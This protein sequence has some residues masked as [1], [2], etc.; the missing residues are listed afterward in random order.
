MDHHVDDDQLAEAVKFNFKFWW[1]KLVSLEEKSYK[2]RSAAFLR[3]LKHLPG[4]YKL[5]FHFLTE[6]V[7]HCNGKCIISGSYQVVNDLFEKC[8]VFM[9]KM[10]RIW[11]LYIEFLYKQKLFNRF[12]ATLDR[13]E[14]I[15]LVPHF[16]TS[17]TTLQDMGSSDRQG[18]GFE[19]GNC[20]KAHSAKV[21]KAQS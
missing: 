17:D 2:E 6:S 16:S 19:R 7:E 20:W 3:A 13:V 18:E 4:S 9:H 14:Y 5:W 10:P 12:R 8:L 21:L 15:Y 1:S 11:I